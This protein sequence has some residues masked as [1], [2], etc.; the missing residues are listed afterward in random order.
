MI[1]QF[2]SSSSGDTQS[3]G[4]AP[5]FR[6]TASAEEMLNKAFEVWVVVVWRRSLRKDVDVD[7]DVD[8]II[9]D[10]CRVGDRSMVQN[11]IS[12]KVTCNSGPCASS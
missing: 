7:V 3:S 2:Y 10:G 12:C 5:R 11:P 4:Q 9:S 8:G 6:K 1:S